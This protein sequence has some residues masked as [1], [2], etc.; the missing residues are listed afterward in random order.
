MASKQNRQ[1]HKV[2]SEAEWEALVKEDPIEALQALQKHR[3]LGNP[4]CGSKLQM[5][6][7]FVRKITNQP[8]TQNCEER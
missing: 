3:T 6:R 2:K 5:G 7:L 1:R 4:F 8:F